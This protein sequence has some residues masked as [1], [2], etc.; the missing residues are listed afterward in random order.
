MRPQLCTQ[1]ADDMIIAATSEREHD[2]ILQ[3]VMER[4]KTANVKF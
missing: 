3:K 4:A 2:E 1:L